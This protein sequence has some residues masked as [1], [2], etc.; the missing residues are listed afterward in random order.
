MIECIWMLY[1]FTST[2]NLFPSS[3]FIYLH[4]K[5]SISVFW[6]C[7]WKGILKCSFHN[8]LCIRTWWKVRQGDIYFM[9]FCIYCHRIY[10]M[11]RRLVTWDEWLMYFHEFQSVTC[12]IHYKNEWGKTH[13]LCFHNE[14]IKYA[15]CIM[16]VM[17]IIHTSCSSCNVIG[18]F[19]ELNSFRDLSRVVKEQEQWMAVDLHNVGN[20]NKLLVFIPKSFYILDSN[21]S[22]F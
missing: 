15:S 6:F 13:F 8:K 7:L 12:H 11:T 22:C 19:Y 18:T 1:V 17:L 14:K 20:E 5:Y 16:F 21:H 4:F 3:W 10:D 9:N 2:F